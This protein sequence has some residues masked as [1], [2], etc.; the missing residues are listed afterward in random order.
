MENAATLKIDLNSKDSG[1]APFIMACYHA[2]TDMVKIFMENAEKLDIDLNA[3]STSFDNYTGF[4]MACRKGN[5]NLVKIL[6]KNA[7]NLSIDP[8]GK[9]INGHTAF[10]LAYVS[11]HSDV[12]KILKKNAAALR[13]DIQKC[14]CK[15]CKIQQNKWREHR[16]TSI[17]IY[18]LPT[19]QS[20]IH[21][22][23]FAPQSLRH[24]KCAVWYDFFSNKSCDTQVENRGT[25]IS[26]I[27]VKIFSEIKW[28]LIINESNELWYSVI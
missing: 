17:Q 7:A 3:K 14:K 5:T 23:S 12:V 15:E 19:F 25:V 2:C 9:N 20:T 13:I 8:N 27:F 24:S 10:N 28:P 11:G 4:H 16:L 26:H 22:T 21:E 1:Y 18:C 6:L